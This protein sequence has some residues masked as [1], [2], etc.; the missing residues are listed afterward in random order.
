MRKKIIA[1]F[2]LI[3]FCFC[4]GYSF[5]EEQK[6]LSEDQLRQIFK[7]KEKEERIARGNM[8]SLLKA[9]LNAQGE[10]ERSKQ[11]EFAA[12]DYI[13]NMFVDPQSLTD[14]KRRM[15]EAQRKYEKLIQE[16]DDATKFWEYTAKKKAEAEKNYQEKMEKRLGKGKTDRMSSR[17][18]EKLPLDSN[19]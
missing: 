15:V 10:W 2:L 16:S 8:E 17:E 7:E 14:D 9:K 12:T 4:A 6:Q 13:K 1:T 11:R 3:S 5:A 19:Y 18:L